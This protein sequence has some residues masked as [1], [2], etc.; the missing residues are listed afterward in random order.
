M[1]PAYRLSIQGLPRILLAGCV[2]VFVDGLF[3]SFRFKVKG[4]LQ[5]CGVVFFDILITSKGASALRMFRRIHFETSF[6]PSYS[7]EMTDAAILTGHSCHISQLDRITRNLLSKTPYHSVP[8]RW[9]RL[10][11]VLGTRFPGTLRFC[12]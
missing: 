3:M 7:K 11:K 2:N 12:Y 10:T 5:R 8:F 1:N 6:L 9:T 4:N